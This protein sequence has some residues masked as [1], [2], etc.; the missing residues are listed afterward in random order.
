MGQTK[1][2]GH[3]ASIVQYD[4]SNNI[5][6]PAGLKVNGADDVM[7]A[8]AM[9]S[10]LGGYVPT[11]RIITINGTAYDL[12][13]DRTWTIAAGLTSFNTRTG[14]ITLSSGDVT[15]ALGF[16]PYNSTNPAG[17]ITGIT[18][19]MVT[20]ALGYTP[21]NGATNPN[22]YITGI[23]FANVSAKPTTLAGYGITDAASSTHTHN[24]TYVPVGRTI[25]IN[26]TALDLSADRSWTV[27]GSDATKLPLA[28]GTMT[29]SIEM[30]TSGTSYIRMGRFPNSTSNSGE[31]WI[32]RAS[33]RNTGTMTVQLGGGVASSRSFEVVDYAWTTVLFNVNSDGNVY[34][35]SSFRSPQFRLTNSTNNAYFT[36]NSDWGVRLVNDHGYI[37]FGPANGSWTHIYSDKSYYFNQSLYVNGTQV[38]TNSGTWSISISGSAS[39]ASSAGYA[40]H[41]PTHYVGGAQ[42]NPQ[43]YFNNGI[44]LKA[45]MTGAWSVW[46]DTLWVNGYSGGDVPWMCALHFLRNSEPRFAISAQ[47]QG[48]SSYGSVYEVITA[49]NI[50]SQTVSTA[51]NLSGFDKTNPSFAAVYANNWFRAQ[52]TCGLYQ[53]DYGGHFARSTDGNYGTW[54]IWGGARGGYSGLNIID[55]QG[56]WNNLM[57]ENGNGGWYQ[58]N[59]L[60]DWPFYYSRGNN[61]MGIAGS[62]TSGSYRL[63]VNGAIYSTSDIVAYSDE[64]KKEN[65]VTVE[66]ALEKVMK[67]RGVYYNKINDDNKKRLIGVIAQETEK[68]LPEVVTYAQDLDE[69]GVAYG[70]LGGLFIEALKAQ[71]NKIEAQDKVIEE[72]KELIHGLTK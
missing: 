64:R 56:Y 25:T 6:I 62:T 35:S 66:D 72:L 50:A 61:C 60:G 71:Q 30:A 45:A 37:Q 22:G 10:T 49:Y 11:S 53:Q 5:T 32:G 40:N 2:T 44:G 51:N 55:P 19:L 48:S 67:L 68:V 26:G 36:G 59:G 65:I 14:A 63:Y 54:Q 9:T 20:T 38:V 31:A 18:S 69:Y 34:S 58:Q 70:N 47:T 21:Y 24:G 8:A 43:V 42:G 7:T 41:L 16:T 23:S 46:S 52:G 33:D 12:S 57:F 17:Y 29:G 27:S 13:A 1:N 28:G 15:T 4:G 39:S 3:L